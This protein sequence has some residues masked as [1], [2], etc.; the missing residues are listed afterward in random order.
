V[1]NWL[2]RGR[3]NTDRV[4]GM[5]VRFRELKMYRTAQTA[6]GIREGGGTNAD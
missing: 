4:G 1:D 2:E 5:P 6:N 3:G